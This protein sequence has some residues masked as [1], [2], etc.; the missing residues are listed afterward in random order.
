M[1]VNSSQVG[2]VGVYCRNIDMSYGNKPL[3]ENLSID[4]EAGHCTCLLGPSGCG[5]STL[6]RMI[7]GVKSIAYKGEIGFQEGVNERESIA[8]MSQKDLLLPWLTVIDNINLGAKL[9]GELTE[10]VQDK[11]R[12]MLVDAGMADCE[13]QYPSVLSG[14][15]RQRVAL[16]RTLLE[17]RPVILMDEPFSALDALT[18]LKLQDLSA[19]LTRGKTVILVTHD[20]MEALRLGDR[21]VVLGGSPACVVADI[22]PDGEVPRKSGGSILLKEYPRLLET[23]MCEGVA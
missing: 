15:M 3:F 20:P 1:S 16:L 6:I 5:K 22:K 4:F 19:K 7:S 10:E 9:R 23:L 13:K 18:R 8:W 21:I 11:A 17:E 2:T 12:Q 14:G